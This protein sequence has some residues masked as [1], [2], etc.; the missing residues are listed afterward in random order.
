MPFTFQGRTLS[1]VA[2]VGSGQIG[3]DIAL[4]FA[5]AL[6]P[7][8]VSVWVVDLSIAA[9]DLGKRRA[10]KKIQKGVETG[11]FA[12]DEAKTM[13]AHLA[14]TPR[15][16]DIA[17]AD[18]VV[19][20]ATE[21]VAVKRKIVAQVEALCGDR[22][23]LASNSSHM[24]PE[25]IFAQAKHPGRGMVVHYFFPAERN[26]IVEVVTGANTD[27]AV[28]DW[29]MA[30]YEAIGKIPIL[31]KS[32]YGY[33]IDPIFE[34][35]F[36]AAALG[37]E[38]GWGTVVEVDAMAQRALGLGVG[39]FTAMNLT[40]GNPLTAHGLDEMHG[41][42]NPWFA[43]PK[44]MK[45]QM[46]KNAPW[47]T[48]QRGEVVEVSEPRY[49]VIRDAMTGA[50]FGLVGQILDT[51]ITNVADLEMATE[52]ALVV[53]APFAWMNEIG[54]KK[55]LALVEAY[56]KAH[57]DFPVPACLV[58][59][60]ALGTPW[61][62]PVVLRR[63]VE[64][65]AVLTIRRPKVLNALN[66]EVFRQ[67]RKHCEDAAKDPKVEGVVVTGYGSKAFVSGADIDM[68]AQLKTASEG[69]ANSR[70]FHEVLDF[71][72][73]MKKPVVCALNG[74][75]LGGG[76]ELALACHVRIA[77]KGLKMLAGQP[78]VNLG[79]I[80]GAGGTQRLP[81]LI[82][83]EPAA[84]MMR[85]ATPL[86]G[87]EA[88][89]LGLVSEEVDGDVVKRAVEIVHEIAKGKRSVNPIA[90]APLSSVPERLPD[91]DLGHRSQRI[92]AI[93]CH[94]ILA[95]AK[96]PLDEGLVLE[97]KAFGECVETKDMHIGMENFVKNGPRAK[98]PFVHA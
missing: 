33:A 25:V 5:K 70:R 34:G 11:A 81:R 55:A 43:T 64:G 10:E 88:R 27:P 82:G 84:R 79:I 13:L 67:L 87:E 47:P 74:L 61:E 23:V 14:F 85:T 68:L 38:E 28:A 78:E 26:P 22:A 44:I 77:K 83:L 93:L 9:L 1:K 73:A 41:K 32:R 3:P 95:G 40:G 96:K 16:A 46:A 72:E 98:A 90:R 29:T 48:P 65:V 76:N 63:D 6:A 97:S 45:Q 37:A 71:I 86:P 50:Y 57:P 92:D 56:A 53:R 17:G 42:L 51:G 19:E 30:F 8:G 4:F 69:A 59:Q 54:P 24:E 35:L 80:P 94:A 20:A 58:K 52:T 21:N 91:V 75:A 31:V 15:Y 12:P 36:Q 62:I 39:P 18:L 49:A 66:L 7:H 89:R 60:A 2:V